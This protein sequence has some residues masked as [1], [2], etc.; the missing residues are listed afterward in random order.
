MGETVTYEMLERLTPRQRAALHRVAKTK[1]RPWFAN[2]KHMIRLRV[3]VEMDK[4][5]EGGH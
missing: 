5:E 3:L 4:M 2:P 1:M